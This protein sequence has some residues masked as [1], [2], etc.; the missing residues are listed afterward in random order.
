MKV[1]PKRGEFRELV[2]VKGL[3]LSGGD[4]EGN[5]EEVSPIRGDT[6]QWCVEGVLNDRQ[7]K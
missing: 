2:I 1:F 4:L 7:S 6:H 5:K 3:P